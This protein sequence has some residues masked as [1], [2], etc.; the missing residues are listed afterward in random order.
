M[1]SE[2]R[3]YDPTLPLAEQSEHPFRIGPQGGT[4]MQ[5]VHGDHF[6]GS[7]N[8][9][10]F[11]AANQGAA[12]Q[13][14]TVALATTYTGL[15]LS[16]PVGSEVLLVV[17]EVVASFN[18][19]FAAASYVGILVGYSATTDVVHTV[20]LTPRSDKIGQGPTPVGKVD[21]SS[22]LPLAPTVGHVMGHA[23]A[24]AAGDFEHNYEGGLILP[25]GG[26]CAIYTS[27]VSATN[28]LMASI[29]W[30]EIRIR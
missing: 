11:H 24:S 3:V 19:V 22:T 28:A 8:E 15:C 10:A 14:T 4:I 20:A 16:N 23:L 29:D 6:L 13:T 25:A 17:N 5:A 30:E 18:V 26:F 9:H 27:T 2:G 7:Y 1:K 21:S 12:G